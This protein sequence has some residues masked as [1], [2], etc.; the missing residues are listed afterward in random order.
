MG[1]PIIQEVWDGIR[2]AIDFFMDKI[3]RPLQ[4]LIFLLFLVLFASMIPFFLHL[5]GVHCD[6][7]SVVKKVSLLKVSTNV[8][9][10]YIGA[11]EYINISSYVPPNIETLGLP[12]ESCRKPVCYSK[13]RYFWQSDDEC[14][15]KTIIYPYLTT[16]LSWSRCTVCQ[17]DVNHTTILGLLGTDSYYLCFGDAYPINKTDMNFYQ[18][19]TC[20]EDR[21]MPPFYY[22]YEYDTGTYDCLNETYCGE[23]ASVIL[24]RADILLE[25]ADAERM[26]AASADDR[27]YDKAIQVK[28]DK[29][30]NPQIYFYKIPIFNYKIWL[31]LVVV[32]VMFTFLHKIL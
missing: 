24:S 25:Q 8:Q 9:L 19:F 20:D 27:S 16:L 28:C 11:N 2:W 30:F 13:G 5:V 32:Y 3:P 31:L 15:N 17:G 26:Y 12:T 29:E 6:S 23:N 22:Y 18:S 14:D 4:I 10:A 21:C 7:H 1:L